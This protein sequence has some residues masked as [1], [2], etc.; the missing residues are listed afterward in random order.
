MISVA[1][2]WPCLAALHEVSDFTTAD[3]RKAATEEEQTM[4]CLT[5]EVIRKQ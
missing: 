1:G 3:D 4:N 5:V 2:C